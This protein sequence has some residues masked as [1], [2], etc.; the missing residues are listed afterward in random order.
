M[1]RLVVLILSVA[2][3]GCSDSS[4]GGSGSGGKQN[5]FT[6][7]GN[8]VSIDGITS[9][10]TS[11]ELGAQS[12]QQYFGRVLI[13]NSSNLYSGTFSF[14][15]N[16]HSSTQAYFSDFSVDRLVQINSLSSVTPIITSPTD[17]TVNPAYSASGNSVTISSSTKRFVSLKI[18][19]GNNTY[20]SDVPNA[21]VMFSN[22]LSTM[23]GGDNSSFF[24]IAQKATSIPSVSISEL[25]NSWGLVNFTVDGGGTID[26]VS[27][28]TVTVGGTGGNGL[29]AFK[30]QTPG[31]AAFQGEAALIDPV[32]GVLAFGFDDSTT[33]TPTAYGPI[34]GVFLISPDKQYML[35]LNADQGTYFAGSR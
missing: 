22:D 2:I 13:A 33:G 7:S 14:K 16:K 10:G 27:T 24:F 19:F 8:S 21:G 1:F 29:T 11:A 9:T 32:G 17:M 31:V 5:S 3:A 15:L 18:D 34:H 26:I 28:S 23:V 30:G 6:M 35:G 25:V 4:G 12:V 20:F